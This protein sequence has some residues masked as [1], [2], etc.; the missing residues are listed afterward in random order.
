MIH[1][2]YHMGN[3]ITFNI[4]EMQCCSLFRDYNLSKLPFEFI[5]DKFWWDVLASPDSQFKKK[6]RFKERK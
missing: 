2:L 4:R 6:S 1:N 3:A 5:A